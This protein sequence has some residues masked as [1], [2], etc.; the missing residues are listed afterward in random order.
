MT[1]NRRQNG[2]LDDEKDTKTGTSTPL[3][4]HKDGSSTTSTDRQPSEPVAEKPAGPGPPPDGGT[5][6]WLQVVGGFLLVL[7]TWGLVNSYGIFQTYYSTELLPSSTPSAISWIGSI[8]AFLL[9]FAGILCGRGLDAG[10]FFPIAFV[11]GFL[12]VFGMMMTSISTKYWQVFLAQGLCVGL[13]CGCLFTPSIA[14][15][16]TYFTTKR[17]LATGIAASG[18]SVGG[19]IYPIIIRQMIKSIG[20]PWAVRTMAFV[21]FVTVVIA[22]SLLRPRLPPRKSGPL[23]IWAAIKEPAYSSF[24]FG[25]LLAFLAFFIPFFYAQ[26]YALNIGVDQNLAFYVL[27]I[28]NAAGMIGR[29]LPN[30]LADKAGTLNVI[31]PCAFLSAVT[32]FAWIAAKNTAGLIVISILYS[33]FSGG[34]MALPPAV[35]VSLSPSMNEVGTRIGMA[36]FVGSLGVL[37]GSPIAGAILDAQSPRDSSSHLVVGQEVFWGVLLFTGI[38]LVTSGLLMTWTRVAKAGFK[39]AKA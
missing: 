9:L 29:L 11:G 20:F 35:I 34:L 26:T 18:S 2:V 36:F 13:G 24:V 22:L 10:Y 17:S 25:L 16:G 31:V 37:I 33:F 32:A 6:A 12:E 3:D 14:I 23:I 28:M 19:V 4:S 21:M 38:I 1:E 30:A 39:L 8:Q 27:S 7:N 5:K 15:I